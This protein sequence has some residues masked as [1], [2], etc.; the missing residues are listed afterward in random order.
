MRLLLHQSEWVVIDS[1]LLIL[2]DTR[3]VI[4]IAVLVMWSRMT[5]LLDS[6]CWVEPVAFRDPRLAEVGI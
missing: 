5:V 6:V 3:S 4:I 1:P 2:D